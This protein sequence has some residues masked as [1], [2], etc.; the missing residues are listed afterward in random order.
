MMT[1]SAIAALN[2][3]VELPDTAIT[4]VHR[5]DDS[6]TTAN[7]TDYL[8]KTSD[9]AWTAHQDDTWPT[10]S[11]EKAEGTS[12]VVSA[13]KGGDGTIGYA[14]FSQATGVGIASIKV[15]DTFN[16]PTAEGAAAVVA[17][18]GDA[19]LSR[20]SCAWARLTSLSGSPPSIRATSETRSLP[21]STV[22]SAVV[23]PPRAPF[24]TRMW[25]CAR[26]AICGR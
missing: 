14:D 9:G 3:G 25:W 13:V 6:G 11:G 22:T 1:Q 26:A 7:F 20:S 17:S 16:Q 24:A 4:A 23:T 10:S 21:V 5:S 15:G 8:S 12:G 19:A 2:D 18:S